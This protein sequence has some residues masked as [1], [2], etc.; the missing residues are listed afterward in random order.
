MFDTGFADWMVVVSQG[1]LTITVNTRIM[2]HEPVR[3]LYPS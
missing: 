3:K 2:L 1:S